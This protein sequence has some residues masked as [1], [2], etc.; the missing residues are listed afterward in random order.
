MDM[1]LLPQRC[2]LPTFEG[3]MIFA[4]MPTAV[5]PAGTVRSLSKCDGFLRE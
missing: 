5:A 1:A 3:R 2:E 4:G